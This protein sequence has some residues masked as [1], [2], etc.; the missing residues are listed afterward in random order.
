MEL[1]KVV[2]QSILTV[3]LSGVVA[4]LVSFVLSSKKE[5][6]LCEQKKAEELLLHGC[7]FGSA[8]RGRQR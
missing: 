1:D 8:R 5:T 4:A 7:R 3:V 2:L 6:F